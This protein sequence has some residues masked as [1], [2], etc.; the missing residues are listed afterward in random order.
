[1][2]RPSPLIE[3]EALTCR[4]GSMVA[5]ASVDMSVA[6]GGVF[7]LVGRNGA[8]KSTLISERRPGTLQKS[9]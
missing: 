7:G 1:M 3:T 9:D 4:F 6:A 5:V 2:D 8:G